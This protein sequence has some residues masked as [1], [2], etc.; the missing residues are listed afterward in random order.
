MAGFAKRCR[1]MLPKAKAW[2]HVTEK[3]GYIW[4]KHDEGPFEKLYI[5]SGLFLGGSSVQA[6]R[7]SKP[8]EKSCSRATQIVTWTRFSLSFFLK[9]TFDVKKGFR[10]K[11]QTL[12]KPAMFIVPCWSLLIG[13]LFFFGELFFFLFWAFFGFLFPCFFASLLFCFS[14]FFSCLLFC[15]SLLFPAFPCFSMLFH[16]FPASLLLFF[17][18]FSAFLFSAIPCFSAFPAS[19]LFCFLLFPAFPC[20]SAFPASLLLCFPAF[21]F[22]VSHTADNP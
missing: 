10:I 5:F 15:F 8:S 4:I 21:P 20:F 19:L 18:S 16:A 3:S 7:P 6:F 2:F 17:S 1:N 11:I 14:V 12:D 9:Q 13:G 22:F